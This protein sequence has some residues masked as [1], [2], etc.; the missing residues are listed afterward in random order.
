MSDS[1]EYRLGVPLVKRIAKS[2]RPRNDS[3]FDEYVS[4]G[5]VGL[6]YAL[7]TFDPAKGKLST[8]ATM[9]IRSA[10]CNYIRVN[11]PGYRHKYEHHPVSIV[12]MDEVEERVGDLFG[13]EGRFFD[14]EV[15]SEKYLLGLPPKT[16]KVMRM[17]FWEGLTRKQIGRRLRM[18]AANVSMHKTKGLRLMRER[19][20]G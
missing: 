2:L 8:W 16:R 1:E 19:M 7:R 17:I 4:A 11:N 18:S 15:P 10:I 9:P 13:V 3:E 6:A 5:L 12:S 14:D 20:V